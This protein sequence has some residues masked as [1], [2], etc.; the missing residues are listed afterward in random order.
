MY[1]VY[2]YDLKSGE[3]CLL[4]SFMYKQEAIRWA[5]GYTQRDMGGWDKV[6]VQCEREVDVDET[7]EVVVWSIYEEPIG[8]Y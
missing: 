1:H 5:K 8:E 2:G 6:C 3:D 7:R 4:H